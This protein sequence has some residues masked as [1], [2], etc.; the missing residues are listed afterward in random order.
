MVT[1]NYNVEINRRK[2]YEKGN[3]INFRFDFG[4]GDNIGSIN[5]LC[6]SYFSSRSVHLLGTKYSGG[7]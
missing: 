5:I 2:N 7:D 3:S 4:A 1:L 6:T